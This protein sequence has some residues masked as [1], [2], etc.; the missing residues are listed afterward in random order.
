MVEIS[1]NV[2]S[3][4]EYDVYCHDPI[5]ERFVLYKPQGVD[6][7]DIRLEKEKVPKYLYASL[8]DQIDFVSSR[9]EEYNERLQNILRSEHH[10]SK[11][12]L[13][14][15]LDLAV[16]VPVG[17]IVS[18]MRDTVDIVLK[19]YM[20]DED[21]VKK[22]VE[23]TVKDTSTSIHSVNVMLHCLGYAR[24]SGY[25]Y[26]DLKSFGLMGLFH[27]VGKLKIPDK[28]LKAPRRLTEEEFDLIKTHPNHGYN[29]LVRSR[30]EKRIRLAALQHH[31]RSDGSGYP[32][33]LEEKD[34]LPESKALAIIDVYEALT[35]WR[36]YKNPVKSLTA[37]EIIKEDVE[38][39]KLDKGMFQTFANSLVGTKI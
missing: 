38:R 2:K 12:L 17:E 23:V 34:L 24:Q 29:I 3:Y 5:T 15:V 32:K 10:E 33:N 18:R 19:E 35:N 20:A 1:A 4:R 8:N 27:D 22:L 39:G 16:T 9:H 14:K 36:P 30:L 6:I 26:D 7:D 25:G 31:E 37:L 28:I 21:I 13:T 11:K